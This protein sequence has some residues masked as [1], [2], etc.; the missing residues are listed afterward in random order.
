MSPLDALFYHTGLAIR[1]IMA[2]TGHLLSYVVDKTKPLACDAPKP[3]THSIPSVEDVPKDELD[4]IV[5]KLSAARK[6][7]DLL[8]DAERAD[9]ARQTVALSVCRMHVVL[10]IAV[11]CS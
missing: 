11:D 7:L 6:K 5:F 1:P 10:S 8:T 9:L 3:A 4:A 2:G